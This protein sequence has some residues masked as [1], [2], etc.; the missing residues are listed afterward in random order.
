VAAP[1]PVL[2][3]E[4]AIARAEQKLGGTHNNKVPTL[5]YYALPNG[6][7]ALTYVVEVQ[8]AS[9]D[10][11]YEAFVDSTTGEI[12]GSNDFVA[13]ASYNAVDPTVQ[14]VTKGYKN[15][16]DPADT[17]SSPNG[18]HTVGTTTS[19]DTSGEYS[20]FFFHGHSF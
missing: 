13:G 2:S 20:F 16:V 6:D 5:E 7:M 14:D 19:T 9:G 8:T 17:G 15:F 10:H 4:D 18:W 11:W 3:K 12:R 1:T